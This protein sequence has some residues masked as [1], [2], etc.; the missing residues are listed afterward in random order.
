VVTETNIAA[1]S[2]GV[3]LGVPR[4]STE[5][6][7]VVVVSFEAGQ[8]EQTMLLPVDVHPT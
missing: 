7:F 5:R 2:N 6:H 4:V 3:D 1:A 8:G